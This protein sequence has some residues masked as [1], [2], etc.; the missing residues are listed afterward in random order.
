M[1]CMMSIAQ[2]SGA[3]Q[4]IAVCAVMC[5]VACQALASGECCTRTTNMHD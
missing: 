3:L 5:L 2:S 1:V 4:L